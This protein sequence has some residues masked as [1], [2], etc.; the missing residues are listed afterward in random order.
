ML[1]CD[2]MHQHIRLGVTATT[3]L[4]WWQ[5]G[6]TLHPCWPPSQG[7]GEACLGPRLDAGVGMVQPL[8]LVAGV[9][10]V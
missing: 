5:L 10:M 7:M 4:S 3:W 9:D 2:W 1:V 6:C 8:C